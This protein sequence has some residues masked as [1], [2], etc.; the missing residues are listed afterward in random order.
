[1]TKQIYQALS[2]HSTPNQLTNFLSNL[3]ITRIGQYCKW[4]IVLAI[5]IFSMIV[6]KKRE[7]ADRNVALSDFVEVFPTLVEHP[8]TVNSCFSTEYVYQKDL[9]VILLFRVEQFYFIED[10]EYRQTYFRFGRINLANFSCN[11][12]FLVN[13]AQGK[14]TMFFC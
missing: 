1:M 9:P 14:E 4:Y 10:V 12:L 3:N 5:D 8:I 2:L 7:D 13:E 11:S 6:F